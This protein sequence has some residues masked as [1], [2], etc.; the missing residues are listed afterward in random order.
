[1]KRNSGKAI[2]PLS[3]KLG[4]YYVVPYGCS[5]QL[6]RTLSMYFFQSSVRR[7]WSVHPYAVQSSVCLSLCPHQYVYLYDWH[8]ICDYFQ[9]SVRGSWSVCP[10]AAPPSVC[11]S[12]WLTFYVLLFPE[13]YKEKLISSSLC[14]TIISLA[15]CV[16]D[17]LCINFRA[18]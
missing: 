7:N 18:V 9:S 14:S 8:F 1:M 3:F 10:Y 2:C 6:Y 16:T 15:V 12:V 4:F 5:N 13:Q 11:L 17:I